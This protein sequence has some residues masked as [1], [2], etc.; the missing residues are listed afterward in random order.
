MLFYLSLAAEA[1]AST[2]LDAVVDVANLESFFE[3]KKNTGATFKQRLTRLVHSENNPQ[4]ERE[5]K[6]RLTSGSEKMELRCNSGFE[7]DC[8]TSLF[9]F[10]HCYTLTVL[11]VDLV[12]Q[13][14]CVYIFL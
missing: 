7:L 2:K 6:L 3:K 1:T 12:F 8:P 9:F 13:C 4:D 5:K 11:K 10:F 14:V